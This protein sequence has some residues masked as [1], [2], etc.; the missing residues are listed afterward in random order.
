MLRCLLAVDEGLGRV[1]DF[2]EKEGKMD[3]TVIVF[4]ADN[5]WFFG[6]QRKSDKR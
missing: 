1:F 3:N 4:M 6:E 5:G 2:L